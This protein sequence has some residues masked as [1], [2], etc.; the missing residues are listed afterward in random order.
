MNIINKGI[1]QTIKVHGSDLKSGNKYTCVLYT[2]YKYGDKYKIKTE[3]TCSL[4][5]LDPTCIFK[6]TPEQTLQLK[7]GVVIF[8]LYNAD[9]DLMKY[10]EN[11]A[12]V[13]NTSLN[14]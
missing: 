14:E 1:A 10:I 11:F 12:M 3:T 4:N 7:S 5:G 13:R 2:S 6:F 9:K 8:E